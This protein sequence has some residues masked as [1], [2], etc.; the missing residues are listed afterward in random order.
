MELAWKDHHHARDQT[1]RAIQMVALLC[2]GLVTVEFK[3]SSLIATSIAGG[4]TVAGAIFAI[5]ITRNHRKL[6]RRKFIHIMNCEE[7]LGL[8]RDDLI[9]VNKDSEFN[10]NKNELLEEGSVDIPKK[11]CLC[12]VLNLKKHN[13]SLFIVRML[14]AFIIFAALLIVLRFCVP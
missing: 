13:T 5:L 2:I 9:P 11:Y 1:W 10:L 7:W 14:V 3:Y 8:H 4:L 12:D 6:E